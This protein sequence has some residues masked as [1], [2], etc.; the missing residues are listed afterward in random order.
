M[1]VPASR[2]TAHKCTLIEIARIFFQ[3]SVVTEVQKVIHRPILD[4]CE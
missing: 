1:Q 2:V 4:T 3:N